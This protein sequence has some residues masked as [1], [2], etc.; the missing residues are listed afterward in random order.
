MTEEQKKEL[1]N[2][3]EALYAYLD[4][5][6]DSMTKEEIKTW[7]EILTNIDPEFKKQTEND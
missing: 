5:F 6:L 2:N 4:M 1:A 7:K 3:I